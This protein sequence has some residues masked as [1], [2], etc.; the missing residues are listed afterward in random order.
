M[1]WTIAIGL[2][3]ASGTASETQRSSRSA[4]VSIAEAA[5]SRCRQFCPED[6]LVMSPIYAPVTKVISTSLPAC[7]ATV[8]WMTENRRSCSQSTA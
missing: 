4:A 8:R 6:S 3:A 7:L 5:L 2:W 1:R